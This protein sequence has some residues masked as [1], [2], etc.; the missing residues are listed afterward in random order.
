M[1]LETRQGRQE[2]FQIEELAGKSL[3]GRPVVSLAG[4]GKTIGLLLLEGRREAL[5]N[6][7]WYRLIDPCESS[8]E[9][10]GESGLDSGQYLPS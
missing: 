10:W 9:A 2:H 5:E 4:A 1:A 3:Q 8:T 7:S 6:L